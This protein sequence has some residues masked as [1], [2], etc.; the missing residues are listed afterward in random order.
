MV[1]TGT[2]Q[3]EHISNLNQKNSEDNCETS[4]SER[5]ALN[6]YT[7]SLLCCSRVTVKLEF[8]ILI[9]TEFRSFPHLLLDQFSTSTEVS[10]EVAKNEIF[11]YCLFCSLKWKLLVM[12]CLF[13]YY[14]YYYFLFQKVN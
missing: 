8:D 3:L 11:S 6:T 12:V 7:L 4:N 10:M 13:D 14:Y 2:R 5:R 9:T 1:H